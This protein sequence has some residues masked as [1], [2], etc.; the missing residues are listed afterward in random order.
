MT[1]LR[2]LG[3]VDIEEGPGGEDTWALLAKPKLTALTVYLLLAHRNGWCRRDE[4]AA[5]FWPESDQAHARSSLSQAL[6]QIRQHLGPASIETRG[7]E[8]VRLPPEAL[9]CDA[10]QLRQAIAHDEHG[11]ACD[12]YAGELMPAFHLPDAPEFHHWLERARESLRS[13]VLASAW[14]G[15]E[16]C[17]ATGDL[18]GAA[19]YLRLAG[20]LSLLD[21]MAVARSIAGLARVNAPSEALA[22]FD[23]HRVALQSE[24]GMDPDTALVELAGGIRQGALARVPDIHGRAAP[25]GSTGGVE[26]PDGGARH[27]RRWQTG[28]ALLVFAVIIVAVVAQ[29]PFVRPRPPLD[30]HRLL[31][32]PFS[33]GEDSRGTAG[34]SSPPLSRSASGP[35][36]T[37]LRGSRP[38]RN[39]RQTGPSAPAGSRHGGNC[40]RPSPMMSPSRSVPGTT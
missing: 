22:L 6:Y 15:A 36:W 11:R 32:L 16:E 20:S 9:P 1:R 18:A 24:M 33:D 8:D 19:N 39:S 7:T 3:T 21:P 4:L 31:V 23:Q 13:Q 27:D 29:L 28:A 30:P 40:P 38:C 34:A 17:E 10:L 14:R 25:A 35:C 12:L 2:V 5:L 37:G 26:H